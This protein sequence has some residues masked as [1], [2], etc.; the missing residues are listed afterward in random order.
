MFLSLSESTVKILNSKFDIISSLNSKLDILISFFDFAFHGLQ[1][2]NYR[3]F[4]QLLDPIGTLIVRLKKFKTFLLYD[5]NLSQRSKLLIDEG[6]IAPFVTNKIP[7]NPFIIDF[8]NNENNRME[9]FD[10]TYFSTIS[11]DRD[12]W[13]NPVKLSD[14]SSLI[15]SFHGA[16]TLKFFDYLHHTRPNYR[17]RLP[18]DMKRFYIKRNNFTYGQ[19]FNL[20]IIHNNLSSLPIGEIGPVHS[21]KETISFIKSQVSNILLPKYLKRERSGDQTFVLI[22]DLYRS[23]NLLTRLNPFV[24][25]KRY[26][27]SI[28]EIS[29]TPLTKEQIVNFEKTFCQPFFKRSDSEENNFD[30]CFKRGFSSNVGLIQTRSYQICSYLTECYWIKLQRHCWRRNGFFPMKL[31]TQFIQPD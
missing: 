15:A 20:L 8:F 30:Q 18:S 31:N 16:N 22:Y 21:E 4:N 17:N 23:L 29:T 2:L 7:I 1:S 9:S 12:N 13:L 25:E 11:N 28:E 5:H 10:N 19:L 26:L 3:R 14:Q 6:T 24:R 27:S